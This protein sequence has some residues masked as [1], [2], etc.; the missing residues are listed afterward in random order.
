MPKMQCKSGRP[1]A[2]K[3]LSGSVKWVW[4]A[5]VCLLGNVLLY[6]LSNNLEGGALS[7]IFI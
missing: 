5:Q 2:G 3:P 6:N 1:L 4:D 7:L